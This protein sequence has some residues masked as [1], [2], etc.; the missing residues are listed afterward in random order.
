MQSKDGLVRS[1]LEV[2][3]VLTSAICDLRKA[4]PPESRGPLPS[5]PE[6]TTPRA[7]GA[8]RPTGAGWLFLSAAFLLESGCLPRT[9]SSVLPISIASSL[10]V[11]EWEGTTSQG[12]PIAF[13]VS[14]DEKVTS[15]TLEYDFNGCS[16]TRKF[17][18]INIPTAPELHCIPGPCARTAASYRAFGFSVGTAAGGPYT[19]INGVFLPR[20]QAKG[21]AIFSEYPN[22]GS[23]TVQWTATRG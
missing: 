10:S 9:L 23:A 18:D 13:T 21:Q 5:K 4:R 14:R 12:R 15:I 7:V 1:C 3:R 6:S 17:L 20:N 16:G 8:W 22:C 11:G 19:Q 2:G